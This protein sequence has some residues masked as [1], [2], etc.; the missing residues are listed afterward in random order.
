[1]DLDEL[2]Q[3]TKQTAEVLCMRD[4]VNN[5]CVWNGIQTCTG[6]PPS[7]CSIDWN[8]D[9]NY[10]VA[11]PFLAGDIDGDAACSADNRDVYDFND[12]KRIYDLGKDQLYTLESCCDQ[13]LFYRALMERSPNDLW[14][15]Y[16]TV[17]TVRGTVTYTGGSP[18]GQAASFDGAGVT[19]QDALVL[20][21][22]DVS[23]S[24]SAA[25]P[26]GASNPR[27]FNFHAFF[28]LDTTNGA[29]SGHSLAES[30]S[31]RV[32]VTHH[33]TSPQL[34]VQLHDGVTWLAVQNIAQVTANQWY[35]LSVQWNRGGGA[36]RVGLNVWNGS[37]W[38]SVVCAV[39]SNYGIALATRDPGAIRLG[40][41]ADGNWALDGQ[42]DSVSITNH[43]SKGWMEGMCP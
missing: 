37:G 39:P 12:W 20:A 11:P 31:F 25:V 13:V 19:P 24:I 14:S 36:L 38:N 5:T 17:P 8:E 23:R 18:G 43:P 35:R 26:G 1:M 3:S 40:A 6:S 41:S 9:A 34:T 28:R 7:N 27:G 15:G 29:G 33:A 32:R 30:E 16:G 22:S 4:A 10:T 21:P 2:A 42:L